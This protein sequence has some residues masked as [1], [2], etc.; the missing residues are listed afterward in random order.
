MGHKVEVLNFGRSGYT[1]TEEFLILKNEVSRFSVD[2][3]ILVFFP[4]NDIADI[5]RQTAHYTSRPFYI[6]SRSGELILDTT[7]AATM[8]FKLRSLIALPKQH[9]AIISLVAERYL[10]YKRGRIERDSLVTPQSAGAAV[11]SEAWTLYTSNP[12]Q[13]YSNNYSLNKRVI[14]EMAEFSA[15]SG[16]RFVLVN[17]D[18]P[19]YI[20]EALA[21]YE[22]LDPTFAYDRVDQDLQVFAPSIGI[23]FVGLARPFKDGYD[24]TGIEY[25][26]RTEGE[27]GHWNYAGHRLVADVLANALSPIIRAD[28]PWHQGSTK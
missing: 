26:W 13:M 24:K 7:F 20:P 28:W 5:S 10:K 12:H 27:W 8:S 16:M 6:V 4:G 22:A 11:Q 19:T 15:A 14:R 3:V 17:A 21:S 1:Q 18:L 2:L 9:S 25:H 23:E